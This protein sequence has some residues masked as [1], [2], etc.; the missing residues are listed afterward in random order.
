MTMPA[1]LGHGFAL[2]GCLGLIVLW[3]AWVTVLAPY[4]LPAR[5]PTLLAATLPLLLPLRGLVHRQRRSYGWLG[6]LSLG[7]FIHG[8]GA[9]TA[10]PERLPASLELLLSLALFGGCLLSL[11]ARQSQCDNNPSR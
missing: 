7:Y 3:L 2:T 8:V 5:A 11:R 4:P 10:A 1:L 6:M 9:W